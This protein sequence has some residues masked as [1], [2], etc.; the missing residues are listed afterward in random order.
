[1]I[2]DWAGAGTIVG[3]LANA[4]TGVAGHRTFGPGSVIPVPRN[5]MH[6]AENPSCT[7][8]ID[9]LQ[10]HSGGVGPSCSSLGRGVLHVAH[11]TT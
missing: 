10:A 8:P 9:L 7:E 11:V 6:S 2:I 5:A 4:E 3:G 1:M